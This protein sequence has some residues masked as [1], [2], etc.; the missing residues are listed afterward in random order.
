[1]NKK[2]QSCIVILFTV[3][4][5]LIMIF[6]DKINDETNFIKSKILVINKK[7][8][9]LEKQSDNQL[10]NKD[11]N[12]EDNANKKIEVHKDTTTSNITASAVTSEQYKKF[13]MEKMN[14]ELAQDKEDFFSE[15][16]VKENADKQ[17]NSS[18]RKKSSVKQTKGEDSAKPDNKAVNDK[19][20]GSK[21]DVSVFKV[22]RSQINDSLTLSDKTKLL[23]IASKLSAIDYEKVRKYLQSGS[24]QDIKNTVKLLKERL[25]E[26]DYD[27]AKE[28]AQKIINMDVVEQ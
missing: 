5:I 22:S 25:S 8:I 6:S 28:V 13:K 7:Y 26:K 27:K 10:K 12:N 9:N 16:N 21:E 11:T 2:I 1:M 15:G 24:D 20:G 17:V 23:S 18:D 14:E 19:T 4:S 3:I